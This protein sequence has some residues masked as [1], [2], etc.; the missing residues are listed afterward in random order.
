MKNIDEY[1]LLKKQ[2]FEAQE[3]LMQ[4]KDKIKSEIG[5]FIIEKGLLAGKWALSVR[6]ILPLEICLAKLDYDSNTKLSGYADFIENVWL[7]DNIV[8]TA[9]KYHCTLEIS[10]F[11][12][13]PLIK[14]W[15]IEVENINSCYLGEK[16]IN[17]VYE[18]LSSTAS[19]LAK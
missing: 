3:N 19:C 9:G 16:I 4:L 18:I 5:K 8:L 11:K 1:Y 15:G 14:E 6:N 13:L 2:I 12:N 10:D 7:A 17:K